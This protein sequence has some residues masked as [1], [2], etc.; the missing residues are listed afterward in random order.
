MIINDGSYA[1]STTATVSAPALT[2]SAGAAVKKNLATS[3]DVAGIAQA[4][5]GMIDMMVNGAPQTMR[6]N[7][8]TVPPREKRWK[9]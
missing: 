8:K 6:V 3:A 4:L 9:R 5:T 2:P 7:G 1:P